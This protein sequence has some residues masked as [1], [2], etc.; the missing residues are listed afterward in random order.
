MF[1]NRMNY[2]SF[3][4]LMDFNLAV[5]SGEN[6]NSSKTLIYDQ[7]HAKANDIPSRLSFTLYLVVI[8]ECRHANMKK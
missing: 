3:S 4:D 8:N 7:I 6:L 5:S 1:T 2:N